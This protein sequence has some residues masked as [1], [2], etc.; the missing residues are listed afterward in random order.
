MIQPSAA[1]LQTV[2]ASA[3]SPVEASVE[4]STVLPSTSTLASDDKEDSRQ[5]TAYPFTE[6]EQK[7]QD[8]WEEHKTF[9]TPEDIDTSKPKYYVLD[10][11]PYPRSVVGRTDIPGI[12][13]F[14]MVGARVLQ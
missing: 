11:F 1:R 2:R 13:L 14:S 8:Y 12:L 4:A 5:S 3:A 7:W 9:R 6:I 10:M